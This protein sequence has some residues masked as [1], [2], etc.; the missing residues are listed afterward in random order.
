MITTGNF[1]DE[2][3]ILAKINKAS[4]SAVT[5]SDTA[6]AGQVPIADGNGGFAWGAVVAGTFAAVDANNDGNVEF[7]Y[8]EGE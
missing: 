1:F 5:K 8:T 7:Q 4:K 2:D 3:M 6:E